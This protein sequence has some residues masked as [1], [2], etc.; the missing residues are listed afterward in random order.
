MWFTS[1][2][3]ESRA[4]AQIIFPQ[5]GVAY[6][7]WPLNFFGIQSNISSKLLE[8]ETLNLVHSFHFEKP[9]GRPIN[10]PPK[11]RGLGHVTPV[12]AL[13]IDKVGHRPYHFR[14]GPT[15]GPT[16]LPLGPRKPKSKTKSPLKFWTCLMTWH[17]LV[18][19]TETNSKTK[20]A[21]WQLILTVFQF[22]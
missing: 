7:T 15:S 4:G 9:S 2:A 10:F 14:S 20:T 8:L 6:L 11:G 21:E 12:A 19:M 17:V 18:T 22:L 13:A 3:G 1:S 5:M 16:R